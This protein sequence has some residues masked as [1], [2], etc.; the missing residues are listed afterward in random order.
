MHC[1]CDL[2]ACEKLAHGPKKLKKLQVTNYKLQVTN[3][4]LQ[5]TND[6]LQVTNDK[7]QVTNDKLQVSAV[8]SG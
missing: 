5:V 3:D 8:S 1:L 6:K 2:C 7:L 4:K